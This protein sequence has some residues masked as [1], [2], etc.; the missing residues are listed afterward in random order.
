MLKH[1]T[2]SKCSLVIKFVQLMQY[3]KIIFLSNNYIYEKCGQETGSR[4]FLIFKESSK[5]DSVKVSIL[6][7]TNSDKFAIA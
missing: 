7:W 3:Y 6:I 1:E 5:K 2:R 4:P